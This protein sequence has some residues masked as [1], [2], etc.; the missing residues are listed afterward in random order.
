MPF[1]IGEALTL[2]GGLGS[3]FGGNDQA[4]A[5]NEQAAA[6]AA[7]NAQYIEYLKQ[8][9][10]QGK[11]LNLAGLELQRNLLQQALNEAATGRTDTL[12]ALRATTGLNLGS[13]LT[14]AQIGMDTQLG[15]LAGQQAENLPFQTARLSALGALPYYQAMLG[16]PAYQIP[17]T[18]TQVNPLAFQRDLLAQLQSNMGAVQPMVNNLL[19][20]GSTSPGQLPTLQQIFDSVN[21]LTNQAAQPAQPTGTPVPGS[22]GAGVYVPVPGQPQQ[23]MPTGVAPGQ[24]VWRNIQSGEIYA[25]DAL[26]PGQAV[27]G[28]GGPRWERVRYTPPAAPTTTTADANMKAPPVQIAAAPAVPA[29]TAATGAATGTSP[30]QST[31][32]DAG[33]SKAPPPAT[34]YT[35]LTLGG[36]TT[37][38]PMQIASISP[39]WYTQSPG[40]AMQ[41]AEQNRAINNALA[42]RGRADSSVGLDTLS[43]AQQ[44]LT[45]NEYEANLNRLTSLINMGMGGGMSQVASQAPGVGN[46][47]AGTGNLSDA[48]NQA[49][50]NRSG[51]YQNA[52]SQLGGGLVNYGTNLAGSLGNLGSAY[53]QAGTQAANF[54]GLAAQANAG[55]N[56]W[57]QLGSLGQLFNTSGVFGS[58]PQ[59]N[60]GISLSSLYQPIASGVKNMF[61]WAL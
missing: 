28:P 37:S 16:L 55:N 40:Y 45:A 56:I 34:S 7:A 60:G 20:L 6:Q 57:N 15:M 17:T 33:T 21:G 59:S 52:A 22:S 43:K 2:I 35:P 29:Q 30:A 54:A 4:D 5:I 3:L 42:A 38:T 39:T 10:A 18:V 36:V 9:L 50:A 11:E 61:G 32:R 1:G 14:N 24:W 47:A 46:L 27:G 13:N 12:N 31:I 23:Y 44:R 25:G 58:G 26:P 41:L 19:P 51:L 48:Y 49:S 53:Q 8:A